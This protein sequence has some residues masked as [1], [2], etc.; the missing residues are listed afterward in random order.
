MPD[1]NTIRLEGARGLGPPR[2]LSGERRILA[3]IPASGSGY[4][5]D[6]RTAM[7]ISTRYQEEFGEMPPS[8]YPRSIVKVG[9]SYRV[10]VAPGSVIGY[11]PIASEP[12]T[13]IKKP[14]MDGQD[15]GE[16]PPPTITVALEEWVACV[17]PVDGEG[18]LTDTSPTIE[19]TDDEGSCYSPEA[20]DVGSSGGS[21]V[22]RLFK[23]I[24]LGDGVVGIDHQN[25]SDIFF[26][27][28][29]WSGKNVGGGTGRVL[30]KFNRDNALYEF[31]TIEAGYGGEIRMEGELIRPWF[32]GA[33]VGPGAAVFIEEEDEVAGDPVRFRTISGRGSESGDPDEATE[34]IQVEQR[35]LEEGESVIV[36]KGNGNVSSLIFTRGGSE[37]GRVSWD[38]GLITN[39]DDLTIELGGTTAAPGP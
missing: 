23:L 6:V 26:P 31:R 27:P 1:D 38:D 4:A 17:I 12:S 14:T 37:V 28:F 3:V 24:D 5:A 8:F 10:T 7:D 34:Q 33:N 20:G 25:T 2:S 32:K 9:S 36:V 11:N 16:N 29:L 21:I 13:V 15:L 19:Q 39:G 35:E 30:S 22:V 18:Q